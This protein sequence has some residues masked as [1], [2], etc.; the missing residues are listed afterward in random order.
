[1]VN[2]YRI[3]RWCPLRAIRIVPLV[4]KGMSHVLLGLVIPSAAELGVRVLLSYQGL[5]AV[6]HERAVLGSGGIAATCVTIGGR[7]PWALRRSEWGP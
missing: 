2:I 5:G 3:A 4:L 1:V 6:C 7:S